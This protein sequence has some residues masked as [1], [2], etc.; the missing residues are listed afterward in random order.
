[1][2]MSGAVIINSGRLKSAVW[3]DFDRVKKGDTCVAVCRH[4]KR[5]L[6]GSSTSGTSHLRNHLIRCRRRSNL[7]VGHL[8]VPK[9]RKKDYSHSLVKLSF[10]Q[11]QK[12]DVDLKQ[13]NVK[14]EHDHARDSDISISKFNFDQKRSR[15]DL[16]RM[17]ILHGYP[18]D[19]VEHMGFNR[20]VKNLQP[21]FE[22]VTLDRI[23]ADCIEIYEKEK[24]LLCDILDKLPGKISLGA[25]MWVGSKD[26]K[27]LC[28]TANY[29]DRD[30]QLE[31]KILSF[32]S[33]DDSN[34]EDRL[35]QAIMTCLLNWDID[36]KLLSLT[37]DSTSTSDDT[38]CKIR[39]RL[40]QNRFLLCN[41][42]FFGVHCA[43]RI[44]SIMAQ[45]SVDTLCETARKIWDG[46]EYIRSSQ[47]VLEKF[48]QLVEEAKI[49]CPKGLPVNDTLD[50]QSTC[51]MFEAALEYKAAFT[52]LQ[53]RDPLYTMYPSEEEWERVSLISNFLKLIAELSHIL[54]EK[55]NP[56]ANIFFAEICDLHL[57]L[58]QWSQSTDVYISSLALNMKSK[59]DDYWEKYGVIFAVAA[60]LDPRFKM[61]LV[62]YYY[63]QLYGSSAQDRI[64]YISECVR[65]LYN[66][67]VICSPLAS[68][69]Q[70]L[71]WQVAEGGPAA[72]CL[73]IT[74]N[75]GLDRLTGFDRF[76]D[77]TSQTQSIKS[78]LDK[79]LEEP[80]FPR[81]TD[82]NILNWW[83]V[84]MPK[85]PIVSMMARNLLG[86]PL[87]VA[88]GLTSN[89]GYRPLDSNWNSLDPATLQVVICAQDWIKEEK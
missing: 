65:V 48:N 67:H 16:A 15:L 73:S 36:R 54:V 87:A 53:E 44:L 27:Y 12:L 39:E 70:G 26:T 59:L 47:A 68:V 49:S 11:E 41:G 81:T 32:I 23:Q 51:N 3:N 58:N 33:V 77:E 82:F 40:C 14:Y 84:H 5:V 57:Q 21:F 56:T 45:D 7:E 79:Y 18:L 76:L 37:Y 86:T 4:C 10:N 50:W 89:S 13:V 19:M 2:D 43:A 28:L 24:Q 69:H 75:D 1:M 29:I 88:L 34:M 80:L 9:N 31:K 22:L 71:T 38:V 62:E 46:I 20:F 83:K 8:T 35:S 6:S 60:V 55:K 17:I 52:L 66:E 63:A 42:E 74:Q 78:D 64:N 30:W 72:G 25:D 85:Y 61:K